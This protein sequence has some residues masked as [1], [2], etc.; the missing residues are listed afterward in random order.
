MMELKPAL[1]ARLANHRNEFLQKE[2]LVR[3]QQYQQAMMDYHPHSS[4]ASANTIQPIIFLMVTVA[5]QVPLLL[6]MDSKD[7]TLITLTIDSYKGSLDILGP[8][9]VHTRGASA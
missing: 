9:E 8:V 5:L 4:V 6:E 1:Q 7:I 3:Q 2:S